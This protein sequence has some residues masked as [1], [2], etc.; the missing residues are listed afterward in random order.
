[1]GRKLKE[2][3]VTLI[4]GIPFVEKYIYEPSSDEADEE[5]QSE[6]SSRHNVSPKSL[7]AV[8]FAVAFLAIAISQYIVTRNSPETERFVPDNSKASLQE[9]AAK[10]HKMEEEWNKMKQQNA[11]LKNDSAQSEASRKDMERF[12]RF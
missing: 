3:H 1:M 8:C 9:H 10:Y 7:F 12:A 4:L 6:G 5:G 2:E 11:K